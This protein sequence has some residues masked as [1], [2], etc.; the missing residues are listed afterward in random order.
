MISVIEQLEKK[1]FF[2]KTS[3]IL[4]VPKNYVKIKGE[5]AKKVIKLME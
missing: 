4:Q 2:V 3:E 5:T 1:G